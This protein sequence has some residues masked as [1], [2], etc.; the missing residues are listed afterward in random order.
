M[1]MRRNKKLWFDVG[2]VR[3]TTDTLSSSGDN[4]L[5]FDV[6]IVRYTTRYPKTRLHVLL[7]FD[8]GIVRYT[9]CFAYIAFVA[10]CGLM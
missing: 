2:I 1:M 4:G 6:G 9:T 10:S 8:V 5:W 7:W 3:Y